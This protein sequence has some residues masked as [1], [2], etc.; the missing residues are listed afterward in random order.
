M[1]IADNEQKHSKMRNH[2]KV[3]LE[4]SRFQKLE[5][6]VDQLSNNISSNIA[7]AA[8]FSASY[9]N[10][11]SLLSNYANPIEIKYLVIRDEADYP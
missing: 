8:K 7:L 3:V 11:I 4:V 9:K 5:Q 6:T 2:E 1:I 10:K